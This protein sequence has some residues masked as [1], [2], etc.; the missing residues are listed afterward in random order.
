[1]TTY[2]VK[3]FL[4]RIKIDAILTNTDHGVSVLGAQPGIS[5]Q[6]CWRV[7]EAETEVDN[8]AR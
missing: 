6:T 1:M 2:I 3:T 4:F 8:Q 7:T 5:C